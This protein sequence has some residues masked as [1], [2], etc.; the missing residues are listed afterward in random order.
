[1]ILAILRYVKYYTNSF[2]LSLYSLASV[3]LV[4]GN[5]CSLWIWLFYDVIWCSFISFID[6]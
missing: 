4:D 5:I 6:L 3:F 2:D 1:M